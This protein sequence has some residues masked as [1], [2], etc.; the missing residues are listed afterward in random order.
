MAMPLTPLTFSANQAGE[1]SALSQQM[2]WIA[3]G[4]TW[5]LALSVT[6]AVFPACRLSTVNLG[7]LPQISSE[8]VESFLKKC[9]HA[10]PFET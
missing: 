1:P 4:L 9:C 10:S 6:E 3:A 7:N 5:L 2:C 8:V